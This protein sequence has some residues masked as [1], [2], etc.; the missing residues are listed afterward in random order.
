MS[1][2]RGP[3]QGGERGKKVEESVLRELKGR[4][5]MEQKG[6]AADC[7]ILNVPRDNQ[8]R[9]RGISAV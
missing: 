3:G 5:A 2:Q 6:G 8:W 9:D 1:P 7:G 4:E